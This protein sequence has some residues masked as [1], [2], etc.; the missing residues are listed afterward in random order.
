MI[1]MMYIPEKYKKHHLFLYKAYQ[2][3]SYVLPMFI[4]TPGR[5]EDDL[6]VKLGEGHKWFPLS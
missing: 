2:E 4:S 1:N 5:K 6:A 3:V